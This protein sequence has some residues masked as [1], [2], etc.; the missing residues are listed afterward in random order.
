MSIRSVHTWNFRNILDHQHVRYNPLKDEWILV[1]PHR[2]KRP[3]SGQ[4]EP[5]EDQLPDPN[6]PLRAGARNPN[7]SSTYVF[8]N[9]FPALLERVPKPAPAEHPLFQAAPATGTC[10]YVPCH[11]ADWVALVPYW[12]TWPFESMVLPRRGA[13][14]RLCDLDAPQRVALAD[15]MRKLTTAYDNLTPVTVKEEQILVA[16][17]VERVSVKQE[18]C[19]EDSETQESLDSVEQASIKVNKDSNKKHLLEGHF[20]FTIISVT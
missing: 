19:S 3:W 12:A 7:Y 2:C 1:S 10:R 6:N 16:V 11:N 13:P 18:N 15:I 17:K 4:T 20:P 14:A 8:P 9:D 5:A